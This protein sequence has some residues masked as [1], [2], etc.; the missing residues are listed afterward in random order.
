MKITI[1]NCNNIKSGEIEIVKS[2]LNIKYGANG[3]GKSTIAKAIQYKIEGGK[4]LKELTPFGPIVENPAIEVDEIKSV[5]VF[6]EEYVDNLVDVLVDNSFNIFIETTNYRNNDSKIRNI[7]EPLSDCLKLIR[8]ATDDFESQHLNPD[9]IKRGWYDDPEE[10]NILENIPTELQGYEEFIKNNDKRTNWLEWHK[11]GGDFSNKS[12]NCPYC[13]S[14]LSHRKQDT[15]LI[16]KI[17]DERFSSIEIINR[18]NLNGYFSENSKPLIDKIIKKSSKWD[19]SEKAYIYRA[20]DQ[21]KILEEELDNFPY[22]GNLFFEKFYENNAELKQIIENLKINS[23]SLDLLNPEKTDYIINLINSSVD[24]VLLGIEDLQKE[25]GQQKTLIRKLIKNNK[26]SIDLFLKNAG[27]KYEVSLADEKDI[28]DYALRLQH[29]NSSQHKIDKIGRHLSFGEKNAFALILFMHE[30]LHKNPDLI[31][32][33][34]PISSFDKNKKYAIMHELFKIKKSLKDKT[35]LMLT[36]DI[37]PI[38]DMVKVFDRENKDLIDAKFLSSKNG[39]LKETLITK[40]DIKTFSQICNTVISE[41]NE[42][43]M[44]KLIYLRRDYEIKGDMGDEYQ[45]L[46]NLFKKRSV[47]KIEDFRNEDYSVLMDCKKFKKGINQIKRRIKEFD[48]EKCL[49]KISDDS[50]IKGLYSKSSNGYIKLQLFR[51][52]LHDKK[53]NNKILLKFINET[54][55]IENEMIFQL[56][57]NKFDVI[58]YFIIEE[59]DNYLNTTKEI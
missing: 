37:E 11:K 38:I 33:D 2:K 56:D 36:H 50:Q 29:I 30:A 51:I 26:K 6:N 8:R 17:Y 24:K 4:R 34:D 59:C 39:Q 16:S 42:D 10:R 45:V 40:N 5:F 25:V 57:P 52:L 19:E 43:I 28:R 47:D 7:L 27:Y 46:S 1:K 31:I 49:E 14:E 22:S 21:I 18:L 41:N 55:H 32:L 48:Y 23:K 15:E 9:S 3:T 13:A 54:Y 53:L 20:A 44:I 35:V 58:P 12:D